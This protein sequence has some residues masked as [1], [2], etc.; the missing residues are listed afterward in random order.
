MNERGLAVENFKF[1][2]GGGPVLLNTAGI[3]GDYFS[4][5]LYRKILVILALAP[6]SGTDV[7][8]VT[9]K[10]AKTVD[11]SPVTEKALSFSKMWRQLPDVSDALVET[12]VVSDTF[13]TSATAQKEIFFI[14]IDETDLDLANGYDCI[15]LNVTDPGSVSTPAIALYFGY[16]SKVNAAPANMP[17][18][19]VD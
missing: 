17:S 13:N 7:A 16:G 6:A 18:A 4:L 14:E 5:K 10:Q 2:N 19:I 3:T 15:R 9:L 11:N 12:A 1:V 8:A